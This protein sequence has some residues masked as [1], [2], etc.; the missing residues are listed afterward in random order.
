MC[1][2]LAKFCG[3]GFVWFWADYPQNV[4]EN[5]V[6]GVLMGDFWF[7]V[8]GGYF[9]ELAAILFLISIND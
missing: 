1:R 6:G 9:G 3:F 2:Y 8:R 5:V 7:V 4:R